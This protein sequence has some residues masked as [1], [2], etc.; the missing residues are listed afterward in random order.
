MSCADDEFSQ[1]KG[2][3]VSKCLKYLS[4]IEKFTGDLTSVLK[5]E[6]IVDHVYMKRLQVSCVCYYYYF[7][8]ETVLKKKKRWISLDKLIQSFIYLSV[9][10]GWNLWCKTNVQLVIFDKICWI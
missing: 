5:D 2:E 6:N 7:K 4:F 10:K 3:N 8:F 1:E 9:G